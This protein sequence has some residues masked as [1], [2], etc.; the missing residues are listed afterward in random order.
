MFEFVRTH[1]RLFQFLLLILIVPAFVVT[2]V[3]GYRTMQSGGAG[4]AT[5]DG[6][7]ITQAEWDAAH[8][9]QV[10]RVRRQAPNVD[11]RMFDTPAM[12]QQTLDTL[13]RDRVLQTAAVRSNF[14]ATRE[15]LQQIFFNDPQFASFIK[16]DGTLDKPA[17]EGVLSSQG[18]TWDGF[19]A[20]LGKQLE[21]QQVLYGVGGTAFAPATAA[22]GAIDAMFQ[23]RE[24]QQ[25]R[26]DT[27][28]YLS[29]V[30]PTDAEIEAYY[31]DPVNASQFKSPEQAN[32]D[33]V[34]L[35][36]DAVKKGITVSDKDLHDY[37][38]ANKAIRYS[39]PEER[40][41]SHILIKADKSAPAAERSAAK[42]KAEALLAE[43]KKNP[44]SFAEVA[45]KNSQD[46]GS[47]ANGG[48]LDFFG[49]GAMVKPFEEA[50]FAL[51]P[52]AISDVVE[53]DFGYHVIQLAQ[54]RGGEVK[55]FDQVRAE[56]EDEVK[57]QQAQT[58]FSAASL[59][60]TN[61]VYEQGDSLK[62]AADKLK[63][64]VQSA[65]N[66]TRTPAPGA[67]GPL[68]SPKFLEALFSKN[69]LQDKHNTEAVDVGGNQLVSAHVVSYSPAATQPL[70]EVS[71]R[72]KEK[73]VAKQAAALARKEGEARL[74][75]LRKA[76]ETALA[77]APQ[78]VSRAQAQD[79][80]KPV[81]DAV[82]KAPAT[83]LPAFEGVDLGDQGYVVA[84]VTKVL[85]R[86]PVAADPVRAQ[87]EYARAWAAAEAQAYYV[88]LKTRYKVEV[89]PQAAVPEDAAASAAAAN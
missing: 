69:A 27:K 9:E 70:A 19:I 78:L 3:Q 16:P 7:K 86:D 13:V 88:A 10:D 20:L 87:S 72:I 25:Q 47:A 24:F 77:A 52:G 21:S 32:I 83:K 38:E 54:V 73:L 51:K 56:V 28:D 80:A 30:S 74:A 71:A 1:N 23:Q 62:P 40:R 75:E 45:R 12:R 22:S 63:L 53:S 65:K 46:T 84:K 17:L 64:G 44:A 6:H 79:I 42:A 36:L 11:P 15:R 5:V 61:L 55:P 48:D 14:I 43:V 33:Y 85:G 35:D 39:V 37:Y 67:K 41:A 2:G 26:F 82:L 58:G 8:R 89:T 66:V 50:A 81:V 4:V 29:K 76:P 49:R 18:L 57:R 68:A 31:K 59:E 34:V 60:F